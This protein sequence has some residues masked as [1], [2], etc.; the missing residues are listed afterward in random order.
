MDWL[1]LIHFT[2][3]DI[4]VNNWKCFDLGNFLVGTDTFAS[5][6]FALNCQKRCFPVN[7]FGANVQ[8]IQKYQV[9]LQIFAFL[10]GVQL[11]TA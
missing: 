1:F 6:K 5:V 2:A 3:T 7:L 9:V 10:A 8:M 11:L 4:S